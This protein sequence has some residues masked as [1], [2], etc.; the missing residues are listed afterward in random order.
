MG[1]YM[2]GDTRAPNLLAIGTCVHLSA[3][4][5]LAGKVL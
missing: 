2:R 4:K 5:Q 1:I 3:L